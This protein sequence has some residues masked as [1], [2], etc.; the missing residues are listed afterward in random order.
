MRT[1]TV[2]DARYA[3]DDVAPEVVLLQLAAKVSDY[4]YEQLLDLDP[5]EVN[6]LLQEVADDITRVGAVTRDI[7]G[8]RFTLIQAVNGNG[9]V[10]VRFPKWR[11]RIESKRNGVGTIEANIRLITL[12][13]SWGD[14]TLNQDEALDMAFCDFANI[15]STIDAYLNVAN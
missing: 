6:P 2:R 8:W 15:C 3:K 5:P 12:L 4:S 14:F 13:S 7:T 1:L 9:Q 11:D 10:F